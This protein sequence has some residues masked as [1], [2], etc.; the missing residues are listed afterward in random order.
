M[1][2]LVASLL[3]AAVLSAVSPAPDHQGMAQTEG[4]AVKVMASKVSRTLDCGGRDLIVGGDDDKLQVANCR[5]IEVAGSRNHMRAKLIADSYISASGDKNIIV[6]I[7]VPGI[8]A[9]A[10]S[11]GRGNEIN[12]PPMSVD[13][14]NNVPFA[15]PKT[16][17]P[18]G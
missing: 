9:L 12:S 18:P 5:A 6:Y 15:A 11:T 2:Q 1:L 17:H 8:E 14:K 16:P 4:D 10:R 13:A 3:A 7:P